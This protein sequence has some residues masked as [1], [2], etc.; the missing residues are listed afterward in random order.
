M[1]NKVIKYYKIFK[2]IINNK[3]KFLCLTIRNFDFF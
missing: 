1:F 2:K 3:N